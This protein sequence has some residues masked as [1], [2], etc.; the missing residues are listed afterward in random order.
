MKQKQKQISNHTLILCPYC[1][2]II[3]IEAGTSN[4]IEDSKKPKVS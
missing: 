1:K 2:E 3:T 4:F